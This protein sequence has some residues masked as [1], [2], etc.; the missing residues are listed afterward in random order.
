MEDSMTSPGFQPGLFVFRITRDDPIRRSG[1]DN[2]A[3]FQGKVLG[4]V[5]MI[6]AI[7][8]MRCFVLLF[9]RTSPFSGKYQDGSDR[10]HRQSHRPV[11][12]AQICPVISPA[13]IAEILCQSRTVTRC[14][15]CSPLRRLLPGRRNKL[16]PIT[17]TN[18]TSQS[19]LS[20]R[21]ESGC[22]LYGQPER[23]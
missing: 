21:P 22:F 16:L 14:R 9:W 8:K 5:E 4:N 13:P 7:S 19:T 3:G 23:S 6:V 10:A 17:A 2:V 12:A 1:E 18:S 20:C 11:R 15:W